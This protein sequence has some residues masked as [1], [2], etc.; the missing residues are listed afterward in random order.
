MEKRW[1]IL[2][3]NEEQINMLAKSAGISPIIANILINRGITTPD[4]AKTFLDPENK[5]DF[6]DPF[7][8]KDMDKAVDRIKKAI[9]DGEK[10]VIYG[11]YDVDGITATSVLF[12][13]LSALNANVGYYIPNRQNEGYG[14][15]IDAM[16]SL[17]EDGYT[18]LVSVDCG[19]SGVEEIEAMK[20]KMTVIVTDHHQPPDIIPDA[21]AVINPHQK[22]CNYPDKNLAGVGVAFKL[23]QALMSTL[24]VHDYH[25]TIDI[26]ALGTIADIVPLLG[27]NR[28]IV[29]QGLKKIAETENIG[30]R[31]LLKVGGLK[32]KVSAEDVSFGLAPRLNAAG[33]LDEASIGVELLLTNDAEKAR[34]IAEK[35]NLA[36]QERQQIEAVIRDEV[37]KIIVE[38]GKENKKVLVVAGENW[39]SGVIGIVASKIV[40]KYY[41]PTIIISTQDGKGKGSCRSIAGFNMYDALLG[42]KEILLSYG[43]HPMAAGLSLSEDKIDELD[44][45]LEQYAENNLKPDDY[46]PDI[47]IDY[48]LDP[49]EIT[50]S[51]IEDL[52]KLEPFGAG[53]AQ[54]LFA[55]RNI[56][57]SYVSRIGRDNPQLHLS[58]WLNANNRSL[59]AVGWNMASYYYTASKQPIDIAFVP[60]ENRYQGEVSLQCKLKDIRCSTQRN[61]VTREELGDV[62]LFLRQH[63]KHDAIIRDSVAVLSRMCGIS[64][65]K[66]QLALEIFTELGIVRIKNSCIKY[67]QPPAA[68]AKMDLNSSPTFRAQAEDKE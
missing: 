48:V 12:I 35:L 39:H 41:R 29:K 26:V 34:E 24:G 49:S 51:L 68:G 65:Y 46:I 58:F 59:R 53:N 50:F 36:N 30:L 2:P 15:N 18:L 64:E 8:M 63:Q 32:E 54:P 57:A 25:E 1:N 47:N 52:A 40:D 38:K 33:R 55:C 3:K 37:E 60:Q 19:I 44:A 61:L 5:Q 9:D 22:D 31:A 21:L 11:D 4:E 17:Y 45:I 13:C 67:F 27:E 62:Y 43:G 14:L 28:R 10:I 20:G 66:M 16:N 6:Y 7:L 42:A 56:H 23:C